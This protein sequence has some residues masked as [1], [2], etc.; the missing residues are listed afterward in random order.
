MPASKSGGGTIWAEALAVPNRVT[1]KVVHRKTIAEADLFTRC[2]RHLL[3]AELC[4]Q[5]FGTTSES[6]RK[7][8]PCVADLTYAGD[9]DHPRRPSVVVEFGATPSTAAH[10]LLSRA[11]LRRTRH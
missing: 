2:I 11:S 10:H 5:A 8:E 9:I 3:L 4:D 1:H 7:L 6:L